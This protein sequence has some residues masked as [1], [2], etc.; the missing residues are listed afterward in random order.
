MTV[1]T[2][3][4]VDD[5]DSVREI[6]QLSLEAVGGWRVI[7]ADGGT[8]ALALAAEHQPDAV[9]LDVMMPGMDGI[10]TFQHLR[11]GAATSGIPV[12]LLTAKVHS[13]DQRMWDDLAVAGVIAKPFDPMT[14]CAQVSALLGW[15]V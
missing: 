7:A 9:L 6:T 11:A 10:E 15:P 13:G 5:D 1:P 2:V 12:I 3:L 14:L 8:R 4:V